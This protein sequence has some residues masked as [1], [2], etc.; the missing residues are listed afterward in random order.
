VIP[1][2][3]TI[4]I[5]APL[6]RVRAT[7]LLP[8][9]S[10]LGLRKRSSDPPNRPYGALDPTSKHKPP[11]NMTMDVVTKMINGMIVY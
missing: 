4:L 9:K 6:Q 5:M 10:A 8:N 2:K 3:T 1:W 11:A 7:V